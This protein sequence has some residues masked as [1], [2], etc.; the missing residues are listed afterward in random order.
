[1]FRAEVGGMNSSTILV[2][3]RYN[4]RCRNPEDQNECLRLDENI[5]SQIVV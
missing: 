2:T 5:K 4:T 3:T 1:M